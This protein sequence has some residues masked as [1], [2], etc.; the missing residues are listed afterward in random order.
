MAM[1]LMKGRQERETERETGTEKG[2]ET[3][4]VLVFSV[5]L[6]QRETGTVLVFSVPLGQ[7]AG[8]VLI[9]LAFRMP[10]FSILASVS[11]K[12]RIFVRCFDGLSSV[13]ADL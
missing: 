7:F 4:T 10:E 6:G 8:G 13:G 11:M 1:Q 9:D 3:G 12:T 5:P 2:R